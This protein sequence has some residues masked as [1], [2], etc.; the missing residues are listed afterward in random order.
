MVFFLG[1]RN[2]KSKIVFINNIIRIVS[3]ERNSKTYSFRSSISIPFPIVI[4]S[5]III[6]FFVW[7]KY[8]A[9]DLVLSL[10]IF[11]NVLSNWI[12]WRQAYLPSW[13]VIFTILHHLITLKIMQRRENKISW[14]WNGLI[15][16][17]WME[18]RGDYGSQPSQYA[19]KNQRK[20]YLNDGSLSVS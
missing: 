7:I 13:I 14:H 17:I 6:D 1:N 19:I 18:I 10:K 3:I 5:N 11:L 4:T 16:T 12:E 9:I 8:D 20:N 15:R 2:I